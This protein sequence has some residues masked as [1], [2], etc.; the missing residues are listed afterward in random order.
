MSHRI[1]TKQQ[2]VLLKK[3]P[4]VAAVTEKTI[5]Y[6]GDFK[7]SAYTAWKNDAVSPREIFTRAGFP[8]TIISPRKAIQLLYQWERIVDRSGLESLRTVSRG[9]KK[10]PDFSFGNIDSLPLKDQVLLLK[11]QLAFI[12]ELRA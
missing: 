10:N 8:E 2:L 11:A 5:S 1:L 7:V 9:R 3:N 6:T 12:K 4:N